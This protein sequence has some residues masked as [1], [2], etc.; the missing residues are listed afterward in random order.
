MIRKFDFISGGKGGEI[1]K[2]RPFR[3]TKNEQGISESDPVNAVRC[4]SISLE[5]YMICRDTA[6]PTAV[7][8]LYISGDEEA[9]VL[10]I[11]SDIQSGKGS[12]YVLCLL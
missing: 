12:E 1:G 6:F 8:M 10:V 9:Y 7:L 5:V 4:R 3:K 2:W 11:I